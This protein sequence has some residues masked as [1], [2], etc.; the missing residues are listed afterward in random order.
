LTFFFNSG[1]PKTVQIDLRSSLQY[2]NEGLGQLIIKLEPTE[3]TWMEF[4]QEHYKWTKNPYEQYHEVVA[5]WIQCTKMSL[6][7]FFSQRDNV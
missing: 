7:L 2:P 4:H 5:A 6:D 1:V 3:K